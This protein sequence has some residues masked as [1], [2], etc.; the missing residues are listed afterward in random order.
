[1]LN[2]NLNPLLLYSFAI[3]TEYSLNHYT[4]SCVIYLANSLGS[5][6]LTNLLYD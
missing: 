4:T 5:R 6:A 3:L 2:I 1:M